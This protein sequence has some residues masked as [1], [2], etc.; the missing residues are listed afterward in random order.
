VPE[1]GAELADGV[2]QHLVFGR[3]VEVHQVPP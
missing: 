3:L 1:S 2:A